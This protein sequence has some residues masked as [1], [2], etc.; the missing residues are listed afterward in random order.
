MCMHITILIMRTTIEIPDYQRAKLL[1]L[2]ARRGLKGFSTIV[3][4]AIERY[5][6]D[7]EQGD[8]RIE[9]ALSVLGSMDE[10]E[11][12]SLEASIRKL[13]ETWR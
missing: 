4:E 7:R 1:E 8:Q 12:E 13:R 10:D 5:L 11:A 6:E 3:Q 2:A 9:E